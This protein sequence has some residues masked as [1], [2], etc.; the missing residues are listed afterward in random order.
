M[1]GRQSF[2]KTRKINIIKIYIPSKAIYI[3]RAASFKIPKILFTRIKN[4]NIYMKSKNAIILKK[5]LNRKNKTGDISYTIKL[6]MVWHNNRYI[7][8][9]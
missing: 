8:Q 2:L 3:S 6:N 9:L 4:A 1:K 7:D 5:P